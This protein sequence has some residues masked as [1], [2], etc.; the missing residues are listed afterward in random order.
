MVCYLIL[1]DC[2]GLYKLDNKTRMGLVDVENIVIEQ[3]KKA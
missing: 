2:N 3:E 1:R